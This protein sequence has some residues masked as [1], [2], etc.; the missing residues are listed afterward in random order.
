MKYVAAKFNSEQI[1]IY[2]IAALLAVSLSAYSDNL[3]EAFFLP[4]LVAFCVL[5]V[6]STVY[7]AIQSQLVTPGRD[8]NIFI[9]LYLGLLLISGVNTIAPIAAAQNT[10]VIA[11]L[12]IIYLLML[13]LHDKQR[14]TLLRTIYLTSLAQ[15]I[16]ATAQFFRLFSP[17]HI[18]NT[19][20][21]IVGSV[22]NPEF[23]A[24]LLGVAFF[25]GLHLYAST[26]SRRKK[27]LLVLMQLVLLTTIILAKSKG[28]L[29]L[30]A[31]YLLWRASRSLVLMAGLVLVGLVVVYTYYEYSLIGRSALW[32]ATTD[33]IG[34]NPLLGVGFGQF[35]NHYLDGVIS[36]LQSHPKYQLTLGSYTALTDDAHNIILMHW[37]ELGLGGLLAALLFVHNMVRHVISAQGPLAGALA[38]LAI[39]TMYTVVVGSIVSAMLLALVLGMLTPTQ[40]LPQSRVPRTFVWV[41]TPALFL[42]CVL[43]AKGVMADFYYN[44]GQMLLLVSDLESAQNYYS[45]SRDL[46]PES[47]DI[48]LALANIGFR[49]QN[50]SSMRE[51]IGKAILYHKSMNSYKISSHML[52]F[53]RQYEAA[54]PL[55]LYLHQAFPEDLTSMGKLALIYVKLGEHEKAQTMARK[56]LNTVTR[57]K[58]RSDGENFQI[59]RLILRRYREGE[60]ITGVTK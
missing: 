19:H 44:R 49:Q 55:Y 52:F 6:V 51:N 11:G 20:D 26:D 43:V 53:R 14:Q 41:C 42:L 3:H 31:L 12:F 4:K 48:Y 2:I 29:I 30:L 13:N 39:K 58:N 24:T 37:A 18:L 38:M 1:L 10:G 47:S 8:V 36:V 22:G 28:T 16:I 56:L 40:K 5:L 33:M 45:I 34:K 9:A 50:L 59:A 35:K 7:M 60:Y 27:V 32:L 21:K 46:N 15:C 57:Q 54:L 17:E 23:L 25:I